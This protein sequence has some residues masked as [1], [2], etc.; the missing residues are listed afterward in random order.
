MAASK[1]RNE[2]I[3]KDNPLN[4]KRMLQETNPCYKESEMSMSCLQRNN[5]DYEK[6]TKEVENYKACKTFWTKVKIFR[7]VNGYSPALP[8]YS[9]RELFVKKYV[10][11]GEIPTSV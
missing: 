10:E 6:C 11:T 5:C 7:R 4:A 9:Q 3:N 8:P 1:N 2:H